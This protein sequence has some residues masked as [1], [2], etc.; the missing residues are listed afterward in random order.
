MPMDVVVNGYANDSACY[1]NSENC[2]EANLDVQYIMAV[3]PF[4]PTTY[5]YDDGGNFANW[6]KQVAE[7][8]DPPLV[9]SISYGVSESYSSVA[10][11]MEAFNREA[12]KLGMQ[13]VTLIAAA[14]DDG[15]PSYTAA[16]SNVGCQYNPSFP[17]S[18]PYVTAVGGT[19]G[20]ESFGKEVA[21]SSITGGAITTG[22]GFSTLVDAPDFQTDS[23][24]QYLNSLTS[25]YAPVSGYN[26]RG[27]AYPDISVLAYN[28]V[29]VIGGQQYSVSGTSA[30]APV[31]AGMVSLVNA[32]RIADGKSPLGWLNPSIYK[33]N[34]SFATDVTSGNN[35]CT[36]STMLCC[37]H[38][39]YA[40]EGWDPV[41]GFGAVDYTKFCKA[42]LGGR[43]CSSAAAVTANYILIGV[44]VSSVMIFFNI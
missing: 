2:I 4:T 19:Q 16:Y 38:G 17:A 22:G 25:K 37:H 30:S 12:E 6:I 18:S 1:S 21:C 8:K 35:K 14:G 33:M 24:N 36:R 15:A 32:G 39:F 31:F 9:Y 13:G 20:P 44:V 5:W 10:D 42:F 3:A 43:A 26:A 29:V 40:S 34:G 27:R 28:Y 23:V 7:M 41:T 11:I